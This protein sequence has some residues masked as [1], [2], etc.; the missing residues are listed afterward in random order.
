MNWKQINEKYPKANSLF[1]EW[2]DK[3]GLIN[4]VDRDLYDF[5]D[6]QGIFIQ[7]E[8]EYTREID[9]L[10]NNPHYCI[11]EWYYDIHDHSLSLASDYP[12]KSR[13]EA[14]QAAFEKAFE[15]LENGQ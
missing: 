14:E 10:N 2:I 8:I 7:S 6:E 1:S 13:T 12:F 9:E 5:F 4:F 11:E 15:I 3:R